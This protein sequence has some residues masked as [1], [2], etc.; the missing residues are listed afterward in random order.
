MTVSRTRSRRLVLSAVIASTLGLSGCF[1]LAVTGAAIGTMAVLDRRSIGAQTE[2]Q[3]IELKGLR[4]LN[5]AVNNGGHGSVSITSYNRRVLLSGQ[6]VSSEIRQ[7]AE[8]TVRNRVANI[9]EIY[10]EIE[11]APNTTFVTKSRDTS[12]TARVKA[13]LIRERNLSSNA[14]KVVT[15]DSTVY[16][17]GLVTPEEGQRASIISSQI[18]GVSRVVTLFE[19][20]TPEE[21]A[22]IQNTSK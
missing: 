16:L 14:I 8:D 3:A 18:S 9:K 5:E 7:R 2:D 1:G 10:N 19:Y 20:I 4:E 12:L 15:E 6:A 11:I 21:L 13:G 22:R 17:L